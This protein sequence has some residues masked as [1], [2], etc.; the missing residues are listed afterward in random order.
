MAI[1]HI[2]FLKK[3]FKQFLKRVVAVMAFGLIILLNNL[4]YVYF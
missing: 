4:E 3:L 2:K 1:M